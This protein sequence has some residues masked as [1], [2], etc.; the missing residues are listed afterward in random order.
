LAFLPGGAV[1]RGRIRRGIL[2]AG[3]ESSAA[4]RAGNAG[5]R[6]HARC[7]V[8]GMRH[9]IRLLDQNLPGLARELARACTAALDPST[10]PGLYKA[11]LRSLRRVLKARVKAFRYCGSTG[12]CEHALEPRAQVVAFR[13][14]AWPG[15]RVHV[16]LTDAETTPEVL[17]R[18]LSVEATRAAALALP[19]RKLEGAARTLRRRVEEILRGRLFAAES[20]GNL[21]LCGMN[22]PYDPWDA[23]DAANRVLHRSHAV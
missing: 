16:Y 5:A 14:E 9:Q 15:E 23:R 4:G 11:V 1:L 12:G 21:P 2:G 10:G 17:V 13:H 18:E 8:S 20:C 6:W 19:G 3:A 22:E 7:R